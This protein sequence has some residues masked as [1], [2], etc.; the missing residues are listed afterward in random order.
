MPSLM[1]QAK[2]HRDVILYVIF[3]ALTTAVN[4]VTYYLLFNLAGLYNLLSVVIAW[5][6]SV[7]FA[8]VTNKLWVFDSK[9]FKKS[10]LMREVW[11]FFTCR[12]ATGLLDVAVMYV[13]VDLL[14]MNSTVWKLLSNVIVIILNYVF[15]KTV[16]F[17]KG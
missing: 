17:K 8:F 5:F 3:G 6:T 4:F 9:S 7:A 14:T 16:I 10:T 15:S 12:I 11:T 13:A 1:K 2:K